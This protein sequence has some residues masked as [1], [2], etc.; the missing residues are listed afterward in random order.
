MRWSP[1]SCSIH[2][3]NAKDVHECLD[4]H[5]FRFIG[6]STVRSLFWAVAGLLS[7]EAAQN[8]SRTAPTHADLLWEAGSTTLSFT[9]DP[10]LNS[11]HGLQENCSYNDLGNPSTPSTQAVVIGGGLWHARYLG[12][13]SSI[14]FHTSLQN[15]NGTYRMPVMILPPLIPYSPYLSLDRRETLGTRR[16]LALNKELAGF[17]FGQPINI[18]WTI[19][20]LVRS[21]IGAYD[22]NGIHARKEALLQQATIILNRICNPILEQQGH[23]LHASCCATG[24][25]K[26]NMQSAS[27]V[28]GLCILLFSIWSRLS[29][30][31][32]KVCQQPG[33]VCGSSLNVLAICLIYCFVADRTPAFEKHNKIFHVPAFLWSCYVVLCI[34]LL[35]MKNS[36]L[37]QKSVGSRNPS[38]PSL[39][40]SRDQ[41]EEW[42]G[43]MQVVVLLYHWFGMSRV[44]WIY[45]IVRVL[46]ASYLFLTGYGHAS[47]F[48]RTDDFSLRRTATVLTRLNL[49]ACILPLIMGTKYDFYYFPAL[50]SFWFLVIVLTV[51]ST[52]ISQR[53]LG[54]ALLH[55][56]MSMLCVKALLD[57]EIVMAWI[58]D[59]SKAIRGPDLNKHE[60]MFRLSLDVFAPFM[61]MSVAA[62]QHF[63]YE[64][65]DM[66]AA[67]LRAYSGKLGRIGRIL[68][69]CGGLLLYGLFAGSVSTK[70]S[71]NAVH[72]WISLLPILSYVVIRN[73]HELLKMHHCALF[74]WLGRISL[75]TFVLQYHIWLANDTKSILHLGIFDRD[76]DQA[77]AI[78]SSGFWL[79]SVVITVLFLRMSATVADATQ[80]LSKC[81]L[82]GDD[83][84]TPTD[85]DPEKPWSNT[86]LNFR[87][88]PRRFLIFLGGLWLLSVIS[89]QF[90]S[91]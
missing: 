37:S 55:I 50:S 28:V 76:Q 25:A 68:T 87:G 8:A 38:Q 26:S 5:T 75:E 66:V 14:R 54:Q 34:G 70:Q 59:F 71:Y 79:E 58:L 12:N 63:F 21:Q 23:S 77:A 47:Y 44:L 78:S 69:G 15:I 67:K 27:L 89:Y 80:S 62:A 18:A 49:L 11:T 24:R 29:P 20:D 48:L 53:T 60:T 82:Y 32:L 19:S 3:Y 35:S 9:W 73:G 2:E 31:K 30:W 45:K 72:P 90:P 4:N 46:V 10:Y 39:V 81:L 88:V 1:S 84:A 6:D 17:K 22:D 43:W 51:G 61:G 36:G 86:S 41:T 40:L 42:K 83:I 57:H 74:V 7:D 85:P 16:M 56:F 33:P 65:D 91:G 52:T 13:Q 64:E